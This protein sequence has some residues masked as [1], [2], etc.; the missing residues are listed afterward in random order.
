MLFTILRLRFEIFEL[1]AFHIS[2]IKPS[3]KLN[4]Q[5]KVFTHTGD[6]ISVCIVA[7]DSWHK[8][9]GSWQYWC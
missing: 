4:R 7:T 9:N 3:T 5:R 6:L 2:P 1:K 8:T